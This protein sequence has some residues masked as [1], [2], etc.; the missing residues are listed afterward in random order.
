MC[1][2]R[3]LV[4]QFVWKKGVGIVGGGKMEDEIGKAGKAD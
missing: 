3:K 4:G 1:P 2:S